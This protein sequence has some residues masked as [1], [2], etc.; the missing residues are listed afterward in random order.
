MNPRIIHDMATLTE[1]V[2]Y[3]KNEAK[4]VQEFLDF[5]Y[6]YQDT[7]TDAD[8]ESAIAFLNHTHLSSKTIFQRVAGIE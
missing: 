7:L 8:I 4:R 6:K 2:Q 1:K 3:Y 5:I